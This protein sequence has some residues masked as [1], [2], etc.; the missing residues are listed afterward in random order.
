M[1]SR[2]IWFD[3]VLTVQNVVAMLGEHAV[4]DCLLLISASGWFILHIWHARIFGTSSQK[5]SCSFMSFSMNLL[6]VYSVKMFK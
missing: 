4:F 6:V 2:R 3:S 1:M 5:S